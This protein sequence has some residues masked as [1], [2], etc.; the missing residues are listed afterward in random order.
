MCDYFRSVSFVFSNKSNSGVAQSA[1]HWSPAPLIRCEDVVVASHVNDIHGIVWKCSTGNKTVY[2]MYFS[3][4][5]SASSTVRNICVYGQLCRFSLCV[6]VASRFGRI[7]GTQQLEM[8][9]ITKTNKLLLA[10][11]WMNQC[12]L[13]LVTVLHSSVVVNIFDSLFCCSCD[14]HS[15][16]ALRLKIVT[17]NQHKCKLCRIVCVNDL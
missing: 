1:H 16:W 8:L 7:H 3:S 11:I 10:V 6:F 17:S 2:F 12:V 5:L 9:I 14:K 13:L 4:N 15:S